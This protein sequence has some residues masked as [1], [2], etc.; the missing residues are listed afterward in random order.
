M[1]QRYTDLLHISHPIL[2]RANYGYDGSRG[3]PECNN[4]W[5]EVIDKMCYEL[6]DL[7]TS[8]NIPEAAWPYIRQIKEK[9]GLMRFYTSG[10]ELDISQCMSKSDLE[11]MHDS[12]YNIIRKQENETIHVCERCGSLDGHRH[13]GSWIHVLCDVCEQWNVSVKYDFRRK[14]AEYYLDMPY[15]D[16]LIVESKAH[17]EQVE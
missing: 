15:G 5:L 17:I 10:F 1:E 2:F 12:F 6:E 4:G 8:Y 3:S 14:D 13:G 9:F 16:S 11:A 7:L